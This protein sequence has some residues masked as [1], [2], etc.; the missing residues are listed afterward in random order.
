M[1]V[2]GEFGHH[3]DTEYGLPKGQLL[4]NAEYLTPGVEV[5]HDGQW[6]TV[7]KAEVGGANNATVFVQTV[8]KADPLALPYRSLVTAKTRDRDDAGELPEPGTKLLLTV[9]QD[10]R[11]HFI[12]PDEFTLD[13]IKGPG[14]KFLA[15]SGHQC[16]VIG[17]NPYLLAGIYK[18]EIADAHPDGLENVKWLQVRGTQTGAALQSVLQWVGEAWDD[19]QLTLTREDGT[20]VHPLDGP[21]TLEQ[22]EYKIN[23]GRITDR[24]VI[25]R[26]T[27]NRTRLRGPFPK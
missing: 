22:Q 24:G 16:P 8:Q 21:Y 19:Y 12:V 23:T 1:A 11:H 6:L 5:L 10:N 13:T 15:L 17:M 7:F 26:H 2:T 9:H 27:A 25:R 20:P 4:R 18:V 3:S 14:K